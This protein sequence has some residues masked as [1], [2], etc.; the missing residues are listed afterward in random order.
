[1]KST[2]AAACVNSLVSVKIGV[3]LASAVSDYLVAFVNMGCDA[4][5]ATFYSTVRES[6][7]VQAPTCNSSGNSSWLYNVAFVNT[8][9]Q[10]VTTTSRDGNRKSIGGIDSA[11]N[12]RITRRWYFSCSRV[13]NTSSS[14]VGSESKH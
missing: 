9:K 14:G 5:K 4:A 12:R 1:M 2:V 13:Y 8:V 10:L 6:S 11:V 7:A 3:V